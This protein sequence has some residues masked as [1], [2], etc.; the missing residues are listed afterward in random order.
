MVT[1]LHYAPLPHQNDVIT[2]HHVLRT[3]RYLHGNPMQR[4][5]I[6]Q[7]LEEGY[8]QLVGDEDDGLVVKLLLDGVV[9]DVIGHVGVQSAQRVVQD[10]NV[11]VAVQRAGQADPLPLAATQV[12]A[13]LSDLIGQ[14]RSR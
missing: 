7:S 2:I 1:L 12:G 9:E 6:C 14:I 10:V 11:P 4:T 8:L 13:A 3:H 5:D